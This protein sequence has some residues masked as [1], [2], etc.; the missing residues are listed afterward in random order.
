M[1]PTGTQRIGEGEGREGGER[2]RGRGEEGGTLKKEFPPWV[3]DSQGDGPSVKETFKSF[4]DGK[5]PCGVYPTQ[6]T[7]P[8]CLKATLAV[9]FSLKYEN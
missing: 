8:N 7:S 9:H 3:A 4:W 2:G 1:K 5:P 6:Q